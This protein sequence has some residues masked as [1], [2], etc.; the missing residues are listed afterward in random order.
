M[1]CEFEDFTLRRAQSDMISK[2]KRALKLTSE[3]LSIPTTTILPASHFLQ[4]EDKNAYTRLFRVL[5]H[6]VLE[7]IRKA[8]KSQPRCGKSVR[9]QITRES[10]QQTDIC[11]F[12]VDRSRYLKKMT[13]LTR[14]PRT[15]E[16][17]EESEI[18]EQRLKWPA[19]FEITRRLGQVHGDILLSSQVFSFSRRFDKVLLMMRV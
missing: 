11:F 14:V 7:Q 12:Q 17:P 4:N 2:P 15:F 16:L 10:R 6:L 19:Y 13:E 9:S 18:R 5:D 8:L 1:I 3:P